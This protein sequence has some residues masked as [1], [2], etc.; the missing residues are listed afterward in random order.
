[1]INKAAICKDGTVYTG[2]YNERHCHIIQNHPR[3]FFKGG[4]CV[5][6]F[7]T[8]VGEFLNRVSAAVHAYKCGQIKEKKRVLFTEDLW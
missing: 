3:G 6:G 1:M 8:D 7:V 2:D 5:Q 4:S